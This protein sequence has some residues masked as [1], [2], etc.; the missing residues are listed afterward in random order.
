LATAGAFQDYFVNLEIGQGLGLDPGLEL[1]FG[2]PALTASPTS[3]ADQLTARTTLAALATR[4]ALTKTE[5]TGVGPRQTSVSLGAQA[6][7]AGLNRPS[8]ASRAASSASPSY[9]ASSALTPL[10][11]S[12]LT[13]VSPILASGPTRPIQGRGGLSAQTRN[14]GSTREALIG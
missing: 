12:A 3:P 11:S 4:A 13:A 5:T 8:H 14:R 10:A 6:A 9:G 1:A 7:R 2:V